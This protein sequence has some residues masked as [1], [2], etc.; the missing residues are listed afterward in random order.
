M[1]IKCSMHFDFGISGS[2][3]LYETFIWEFVTS[4]CPIKV[5]VGEIV[6][7]EDCT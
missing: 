1:I 6:K 7:K 5:T 4:N 2:I 3:L